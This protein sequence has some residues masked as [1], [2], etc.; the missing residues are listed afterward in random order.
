MVFLVEIQREIAA[1]KRTAASVGSYSKEE[2]AIK[3][4]L[5][6]KAKTLIQTQLSR[7]SELE[8]TYEDNLRDLEVQYPIRNKSTLIKCSLV[9]L[10]IVGVFSLNSIPEMNKLG[11]GWTAL[12]GVFLLLLLTERDDIDPILARVEWSTLLFF[13]SLFILMEALSKMGLIEWIGTQTQSVIMSVDHEN[14]LTVA[15]L[16]ILW[17][18]AAASAFVDNIPLTTMMVRVATTLV[19]NRELGLPLQ[20]L[21]W[22]LSFGA[23]F[24][25]WKI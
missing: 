8:Q 3:E 16:L 24:G 11:I 6:E 20:P 1:W 12:L 5:T 7:G 25:G 18:S 2:E 9:L 14:R 10:L 21:I 19:E 23:C 4:T 15:I 17:V 22:A 13:A